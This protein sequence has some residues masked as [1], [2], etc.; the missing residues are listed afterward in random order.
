MATAE[1]YSKDRA[2]LNMGPKQ[3]PHAHEGGPVLSSI[4][5]SS[6]TIPIFSLRHLDFFNLFALHPAGIFILTLTLW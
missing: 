4:F 6:E 1:H 2:L 3:H 5:S